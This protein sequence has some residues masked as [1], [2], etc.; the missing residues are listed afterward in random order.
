VSETSISSS[1]VASSVSPTADLSEANFVVVEPSRTC[2]D[3]YARVLDKVGK[4][5]LLTIGTRR[6]VNGV[7]LERTRL[8]PAIGLV[9]FAGAQVLSPFWA[10]TLRFRLLGWSDRWAKKQLRPGDHVLSSYGYA[11]E[12]FKFAHRHGGKTFLDAGNSHLQNF[13]EVISEEHRRWNCSYPPFSPY[14]YKRSLAM[15]EEVD[16]VLSPST[17]V[18]RSFL[19]RGYAPERILQNIYPVDLSLFQPSRKPRPRNQPLTVINT[20]SVCLRKGS[21][22][23]MEAF[24]IIQKQHPSARLKLTRFIQ[25][26]MKQVLPK[27]RDL[28]ID[29]AP[30]L[31]PAELVERLQSADVFVLPSLEEGLVRT[32]CEAM[33]CGLQ[34]VVTPNT[35]ANDFVQAGMN[36]EVVPIR[37]SQAIAEA[38]LQCWERSQNGPPSN[39]AEIHAQLSPERF[40]RTL[41]EQLRRIGFLN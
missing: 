40:E 5:R 38:I 12:C 24:R 27:Y 21:P 39:V 14:W 2:C 11:N 17:H 13:W 23:L 35:G 19:E 15:L 26:D 22:Y 41:L 10:E 18:T 20:G 28:P 3:Y 7:S 32:A 34:V 6:G 36:G 4:L 29:W 30:V 31:P 16:Y 33:A 25:D 9:G 1:S 37:D 8:K